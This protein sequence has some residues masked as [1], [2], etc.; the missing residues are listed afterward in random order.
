MC[1]RDRSW[2]VI[3]EIPQGILAFFSS[4]QVLVLRMAENLK[5]KEPDKALEILNDFAASFP[6]FV[7]S[8]A[9]SVPS[10]VG[11]YYEL[12]EVQKAEALVQKRLNHLSSQTSLTEAQRNR[13]EYLKRIMEQ[14]SG[15]KNMI[16]QL[17]KLL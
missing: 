1:I 2:P 8:K 6:N 12:K 11:L 16:S 9:A 3:N 5:T 15:D 17:E 4:Y 14:N 7:E 10:F 13:L